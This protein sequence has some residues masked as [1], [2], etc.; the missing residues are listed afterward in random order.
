MPL[1]KS[2]TNYGGLNL[3][4]ELQSIFA[5]KESDGCR[6]QWFLKTN[7]MQSLEDGNYLLMKK[8]VK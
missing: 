4:H 3:I 1:C 8:I 5:E 6:S 2:F 7:E